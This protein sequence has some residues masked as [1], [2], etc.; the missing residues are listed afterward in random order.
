MDRIGKYKVIKELGAGGFGAVYLAKDPRLNEL[1]A[2]KVFHIRDA[3]L[4]QQA[5]SATSDAGEVLKKRFLNEARTL[6]QLNRNAHI[7]DVFE[8]DELE[9]GTPYYVMPYLPHSLKD[10]LGSDA[11][12]AALIAEL[13]AED[14]PKRLPIAKA[15]VYLEQCLIALKAVHKAGL[16]HR[17]IKPANLLLDEHGEVKLCDFG[18]AKVPDSD[19]S[20]SGI[21]MGSRNYMAPE[22]RQSAKHVDASSD[23]YSVGVLAYRM[24]TGTLP[25][26]RFADPKEYQPGMSEALNEWVLTALAQQ[27]TDRFSDGGAMLVALKGITN[28]QSTNNSSQDEHTGTWI[29]EGSTDIKPELKPLQDR[30]IKLLTEQGEI[31]P[32]DHSVLQA[33][34]DI[35][36]LP[37]DALSMMI[38]QTQQ[39]LMKDD[40]AVK[41][42]VYWVSSL[43]KQLEQGDI[44]PQKQAILIEVGL[45]STAKNEEEL[46][47]ILSA[48]LPAE[49]ST[50]NN[51]K[52][53]TN[54]ETEKPTSAEQ[55]R[56]HK[57]SGAGNSGERKS[58]KP[59]LTKKTDEQF[60]INYMPI[61]VFSSIKAIPEKKIIEMIR[62]G[63]YEG[64]I[65]NQEWYV[66]R[67]EVGKTE[68]AKHSSSRL[69]KLNALNKEYIPV[70][71]FAEFKNITSEKAIAMIRDGFYEGHIK[72]NQWYVSFSETSSEGA[73]S[74]S[75][76][77]GVFSILVKGDYGL[78]K[79]YWSFGVIGILLFVFLLIFGIAV[80]SLPVF[81]V[82]GIALFVYWLSATIGIWR[83][84]VKYQGP[85]YW[86]V[87]AKIFVVVSPLVSVVSLIYWLSL[88]IT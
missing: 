64:H 41:G 50:T 61:S 83:A 19:N 65:R 3:S 2:I 82:F 57:Q 26:G 25:E 4:A 67:K 40:N 38:E 1:V 59:T 29:E 71:E 22:Q 75:A 88:V 68:V 45:A 39:Q 86:A 53:A 9:D 62:S 70:E 69:Q 33:F 35:G 52:Q 63:F 79:T 43:N 76:T 15:L 36:N 30:I 85:K 28:T 23:M 78:P 58:K 51:H 72:D 77:K 60:D 5:T 47:A 27:K 6:R 54:T 21:G 84:S 7:V 10:E 55:Q 32:S 42:L 13:D 11:T 17:D 74:S 8:F 34:A 56:S 66:S 46:N 49:K 81:L 37:H 14:R 24:L 73:S 48:K 80:K 87:L 12:D 20:Q 44:N 31:K 18:I 16:V